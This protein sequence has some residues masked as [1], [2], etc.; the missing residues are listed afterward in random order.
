MKHE[1]D[2]QDRVNNVKSS[3]RILGLIALALVFLLSF[4]GCAAP[5]DQNANE[6]GS[7]ESF[8]LNDKG[9][10]DT[11]SENTHN[12]SAPSAETLRSQLAIEEDYRDSFVHGEKGSE[13]QKYI[14]LF[15]EI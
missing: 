12:N 11:D 3:W 2:V 13:F 15:A 7:V 14:V 5:S 8:E 10:E 6:T 4:S 9:V 1:C